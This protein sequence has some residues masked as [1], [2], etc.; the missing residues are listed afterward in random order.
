MKNGIMMLGTLSSLV[1]AWPV[2][3][4]GLAAG[5]IVGISTAVRESNKRLKKRI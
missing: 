1:G 2:A 4:F 5:A 3:A